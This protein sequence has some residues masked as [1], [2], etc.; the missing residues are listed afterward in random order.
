MENHN[1]IKQ[2]LNWEI[3]NIMSA[4]V[5]IKY[6]IYSLNFRLSVCVDHMWLSKN[7]HVQNSLIE[8]LK[9]YI[10]IIRKGAEVIEYLVIVCGDPF[11]Y[12]IYYYLYNL[13]LRNNENVDFSIAQNYYWSLS[14]SF[15]SL[16]YLFLFYFIRINRLGS[17]T[18]IWQ[19]KHSKI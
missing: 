6:T 14:R 7:R 9:M 5:H 13:S 16:K 18:T 12:I 11:C 10:V 1:M 2:L 8:E 3:G 4:D 19:L 15:T 17:I